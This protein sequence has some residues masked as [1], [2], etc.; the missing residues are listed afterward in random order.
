MGYVFRDFQEQDTGQIKELFI[1]THYDAVKHLSKEKQEWAER[2]IFTEIQKM[3]DLKNHYDKMF[4]I[5]EEN[6][7]DMVRAF[8]AATHV[9]N[10]Q[11]ELK[12]VVCDPEQQGKGLGRMLMI[13][14]DEYVREQGYKQEILWTYAHLETAIKIYEKLGYVHQEHELPDGMYVELNP[15]YM[16]RDM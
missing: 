14:F 15:M 12:N 10:D 16:V 13:A 1:F 3:T 5:V 11:I 2:D 7:P 6:T 9:N 8:C 4:I